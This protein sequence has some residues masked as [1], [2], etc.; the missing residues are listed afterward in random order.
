MSTEP[1]DD[2]SA[3]HSDSP[4]GL[5][6]IVGRWR[7]EG[8]VVSEPRVPVTGTDIYDLL[9]GGHFLVHY[10]DVRVGDKLVKAIE[11]IGEPHTEGEPGTML[12]RSYDIDG[13]TEVM[14]VRI[15]SSGTWHFSGGPEV[16]PAARR[17]AA[18]SGTA[19]VRSTLRVADDGST[20]S[21]FWERTD[22]GTTWLP[23]MEIAFT[24]M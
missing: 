21:A 16:S 7:T 15:D 20:M 24:R 23:W 10:V 9:P 2:R 5:A 1:T 14:R 8:H 19:A 11:I 13:A 12:A 22:D 6:A 4:E 3:G 18:T 17:D